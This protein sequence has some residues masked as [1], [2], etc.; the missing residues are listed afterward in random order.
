MWTKKDNGS[1]VNWQQATDYCRKLQLAGHSNWRLPTIDELQGIYDANVDVGGWHVK[2]KLQL[3]GWDW[4]SSQDEASEEAWVF[5]FTRGMRG[6]A[7]LRVFS[8]ERALC[9]RPSGQ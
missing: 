1:D 2:G 8:G 5:F 4:S 3:S 6:S 7:P 9:V